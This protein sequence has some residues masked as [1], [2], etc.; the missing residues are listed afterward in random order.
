MIKDELPE[1]LGK[2]C[3]VVMLLLVDDILFHNRNLILGI[4]KKRHNP[5][6]NPKKQE[7]RGFV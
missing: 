2:G 3:L 4:R 1:F 7:M 6:P 5:L